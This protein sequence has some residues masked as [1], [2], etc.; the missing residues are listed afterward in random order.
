M[1]T[2][3]QC[4]ICEE[5]FPNPEDA[6]A[7]ESKGVTSKMDVQVGD[8]VAVYHGGKHRGSFGW[9]NGGDEGEKWTRKTEDKWHGVG[10]YLIIWVVTAVTPTPR[11]GNNNPHMLRIH[12]A[13][14]ALITDPSDG[15]KR[16][17]YS[18]Y[19]NDWHIPM[20]RLDPQPTNL[21]ATDLIG[22]T[23]TVS[24]Q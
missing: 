23:S 15:S 16:E 1:K 2:L 12:L 14:K 18:G 7:C 4:E 3:H 10:L 11:Y 21:D 22:L 19:T 17:Y 6:I 24:V 13:T 8:F 9:F 5:L 20:A